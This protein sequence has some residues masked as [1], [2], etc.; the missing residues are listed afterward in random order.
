[1][2]VQITVIV[3]VG[4]TTEDDEN[5]DTD[6]SSFVYSKIGNE[7][8]LYVCR[9]SW[10]QGRHFTGQPRILGPNSVLPFVRSQ[11]RAWSSDTPVASEQWRPWLVLIS[12]VGFVYFAFDCIL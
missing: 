9:V 10:N 7:C 6:S 12:I 1:M 3:T 2:G 4:D 8:W 11:R 5:G